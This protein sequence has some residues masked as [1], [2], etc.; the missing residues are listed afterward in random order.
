MISHYIPR[1]LQ[2]NTHAFETTDSWFKGKHAARWTTVADYIKQNL[3]CHVRILNCI[4]Y[5]SELLL[6]TPAHRY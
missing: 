2:K 5:E 3:S 4:N 6:V 1:V